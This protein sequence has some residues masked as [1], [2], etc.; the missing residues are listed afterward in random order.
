M[1]IPR[2]YIET[3]VFNACFDVDAPE[4]TRTAW[5][6]FAAVE[7]VNYVPFTSESVR[8]ETNEDACLG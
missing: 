2:I 5:E 3:T 8:R 7:R 6:L 1:R 4:N